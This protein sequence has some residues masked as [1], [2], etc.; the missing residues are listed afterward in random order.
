[1]TAGPASSARVGGSPPATPGARG[2]GGGAEEGRDARHVLVTGASSGIGSATVAA[3]AAAGFRVAGTVRSE[4]DA[5]ALRDVGVEAIRLDVTDAASIVAAREHARTWLGGSPLYG[6]VNNAGT[7]AAGPLEHVPLDVVREA[8]EV[9]AI[10]VLAVTRAFLPE[11]RA[12]PGRIVMMSSISG[13]VAFPFS[14]AYAASKWALEAMSDALRRELL[15]EGID[16]IVVE[17]GPVETPMWDR[18]RNADLAPYIGTRYENALRR[19]RRRAEARG[20]V[21]P[22]ERVAQ[23]VTRALRR[24]RPGTRRRVLAGMDRWA[25]AVLE[26]LPD[27]WIDR[28]LASRVAR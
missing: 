4:R 9:N 15:P 5:A 13:L 17:P 24:R 7:P 14:G 21:M 2:S 26:R 8:L 22:P 23:A 18:V 6:L 19:A 27:R 28:L 10:G 20:G 3:L 16:V 25:F 1:M 12:G 11:L